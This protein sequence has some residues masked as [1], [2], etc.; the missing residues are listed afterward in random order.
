LKLIIKNRVIDT[1]IETILKRVRSETRYLKDIIKKKEDV[2]CTCP[3]H[4]DGNESKP[5]C[6]VYDDDGKLVKGT[7]HCFACGEKGSLAKL[8]GKC[9]NRD[10]RWGEQWLIENFSSTF[11]E[12]KE[13]LEEITLEKKDTSIDESVLETFEYDNKEALEY[14]INK[15]HLNKDI[16]DLFQV[17]YDPDTT[18]VTF[19]C[20]DEHGKLVGIFKRNI[21]TKFFT[22]PQI[23][24]KPVY[25]LDYVIR[26]GYDKVYVVE[27]QIN[28]LTLWGWG[29]PAVALFG[30]GSNYQYK[31][32][33]KSGIRQYILAFDGD[34]AGSVGAN[35]FV[36]NVFDALITKVV[37]PQGKDVND[38]TKEEFLSLGENYC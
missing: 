33:Q 17:G 16:V 20:R 25:L 35:R 1:P 34:L 12:Q 2:I 4:K 3:F 9:Y 23:D 32:L 13:Y 37:L 19:P 10:T 24:P 38:L 30:T 22:I 14:L 15:R 18:A 36:N 21:Y 6:F 11:V 7:F 31:V 28:A 8:V 27:S 5:A 26:N 29:F